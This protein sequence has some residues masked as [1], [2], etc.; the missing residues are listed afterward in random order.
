MGKFED[1]LNFILKEETQYA[2]VPV[3][4]GV[5]MKV[6]DTGKGSDERFLSITANKI[7]YYK[8][9]SVPQ[10]NRN[11]KWSELKKFAR[12]GNRLE[13]Y[14]NSNEKSDE[15]MRFESHEAD[16]ILAII[17]SLLFRIYTSDE[18]ESIGFNPKDPDRLEFSTFALIQR[19]SLIHI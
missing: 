9:K 5:V 3:F 12:N 2:Q 13:F 15:M 11:H 18:L 8:S 16:Y 19:L 1:Q 17:K 14:F 4:I 6:H 7:E 10:H